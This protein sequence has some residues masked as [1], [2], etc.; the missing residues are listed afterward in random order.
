MQAVLAHLDQTYGGVAGYL[1][2]AGVSPAV[3]A[4][5]RTQ[6]LAPP[7]ERLW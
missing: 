1:A 6:L 4:Q 5:I 7:E 2:A 3:L